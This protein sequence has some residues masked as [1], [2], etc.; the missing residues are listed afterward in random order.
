MRVERQLHN[1]LQEAEETE[2]TQETQEGGEHSLFLPF[3]R[4]NAAILNFC[5]C[6]SR[7]PEADAR[8]RWLFWGNRITLEVPEKS[9]LAATVGRGGGEPIGALTEYSRST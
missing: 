5:N 1:L 3:G 9:G 4:F 7:I 6:L 2:V 8:G